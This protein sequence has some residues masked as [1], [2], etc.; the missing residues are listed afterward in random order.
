MKYLIDLNPDQEEFLDKY[1]AVANFKHRREEYPGL[2]INNFINSMIKRRGDEVKAAFKENGQT[3]ELKMDNSL[4]KES[5]G[6]LYTDGKEY[7]AVKLRELKIMQVD[8]GA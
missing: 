3:M 7:F 8:T 1:L 4:F 2:V 6:F 5:D